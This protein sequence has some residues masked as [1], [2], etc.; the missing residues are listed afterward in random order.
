MIQ[1]FAL[2]LAAVLLPAAASASGAATYSAKPVTPVAAKRIVVRDIIWACG[3]ATCQGATEY[4][5]PLVLCQ[6][7]ARQ[8][9][10]IEYFV[11]NGRALANADLDK[12]N[13]VARGGP[14]PSLGRN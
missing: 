8:A 13:S 9:G 12:C 3:P 1:H 2:S 6:G 11:A 7:L 4:G 5:R 10:L 14:R